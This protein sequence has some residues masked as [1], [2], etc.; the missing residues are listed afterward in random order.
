VAIEIEC[1]DCHKRYNV[2]DTAAGK[3]AVCKACG[4]RI[5]VPGAVPKEPETEPGGAPEPTRSAEAGPLPTRMVANRAIAGKT[6]S[7][8]GQPIT[9]GQSV[10]NCDACG[11]SFHETCWQRNGGCGTA[12]CSNAPLPK[13][14]SK[15]GV[16]AGP[17]A[18][19]AAPG[20]SPGGPPPPPGAPGAG[21][22]PCPFC[23]EQIAAAAVKCRH[24]G[25]FLSRAGSGPGG[26]YTGPKQ[27]CGK[28]VGSLV[29]GIISFI[30]CGVVVGIVAISLGV[31]AQK[32]I[33]QSRGRL[34]GAGMAKAGI[35]CGT[36][37]L[38]LS[39]IAILIQIIA[40]ASQ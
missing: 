38:I 33:A 20:R 28:A 36:I 15:P 9:L 14:Q 1:P 17:G 25:E 34:T 21:T 13:L 23:G 8:C 3:T 37:G 29:C 19:G 12:G 40:A 31:S 10:H 7:I 39:V 30:C 22:K 6:C 24:C 11:Q 16:G 26:R 5:P 35:I 4:A 2:P 18:G 27:T 32:E